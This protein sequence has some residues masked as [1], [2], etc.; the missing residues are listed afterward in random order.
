MVVDVVG[1]GVTIFVG[2]EVVVTVR[3]S[4]T[5]FAIVV[6]P[7][8]LSFIDVC[9][10]AQYCCEYVATL[11]LSVRL[12]IRSNGSARLS[13]ALKWKTAIDRRNVLA[14]GNS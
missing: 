8:V 14:A 2:V 6:V 11:A 13:R 3:W 9:F 7:T 5:V 4:E 12:N 10:V 1:D